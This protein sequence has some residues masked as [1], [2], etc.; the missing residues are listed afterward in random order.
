[1]RIFI[2]IGIVLV[3]V[4]GLAAFAYF[5]NQPEGEVSATES[6]AAQVYT[7]AVLTDEVL[8]KL[9]DQSQFTNVKETVQIGIGSEIKTSKTGRA[10]LLYPNG[11]ITAI[12][13][14][15]YLKIEAL[16]GNGEHSRIELVFGSMWSKIKNILGT[17][18]YYEVGT[19]NIVASVRG[20]IF[21]LE[22][23]NQIATVYGLGNSVKVSS[24]NPQTKQ[25]ISNTSVIV[26]SGQK[27]VVSGTPSASV[28]ATPRVQ[29][30]S[31]SDLSREIISR[32]ILELDDEDLDDNNNRG[33]RSLLERLR[34]RLTPTSSP[35][36]TPKPTATPRP[37]PTPTPTPTPDTRIKLESVIPGTIKAGEKFTIN[38]TNF[39]IGN[40]KK[41][42]TVRVGSMNTTFTVIDAQTIFVTTPALNTGT[43][44]V[45]VISTSNTTSTLS[46][47]LKIQ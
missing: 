3:L 35:T 19:D 33:I 32:Y 42:S 2:V 6:P 38:G 12:D 39:I 45:K 15:S 9:P 36:K 46:D 47:A 28:S 14:D 34:R 24:R 7:L 16:D 5:R 29:S 44:D 21:A 40:T 11:T 1:M 4:G 10:K 22:Y 43:Y 25:A 41:V 8:L 26:D 37:S 31:D 20:T 27:V 17:G 30:I 23:R 18:D 13:G